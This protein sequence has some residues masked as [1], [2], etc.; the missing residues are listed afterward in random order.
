MLCTLGR[1]T[2]KQNSHY[3]PGCT[4]K[5]ADSTRQWVWRWNALTDKS[6]VTGSVRTESRI[7][8]CK[9]RHTSVIPWQR[10]SPCCYFFYT[11]RPPKKTHSHKKDLLYKHAL[12]KS[13]HPLI[14]LGTS[15]LPGLA[16]LFCSVFHETSYPSEIISNHIVMSVW[17]DWPAPTVFIYP[18]LLC[19]YCGWVGYVVKSFS[20][21]SVLCGFIVNIYEFVVLWGPRQH[22]VFYLENLPYS[23]CCSAAQLPVWLTLT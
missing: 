11:E 18:C 10:N 21:L 12:M 13:C 23:L 9:R 3:L 1:S 7:S 15:L 20:Y 2:T 6:F 17:C 19:L 8:H 22:R 16:P 14:T 4:W 5:G